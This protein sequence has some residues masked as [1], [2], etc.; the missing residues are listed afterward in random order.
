MYKLPSR[1][2]ATPFRALM[3]SATKIVCVAGVVCAAS[4]PA[5]QT[6]WTFHDLEVR[7]VAE[8]SQF[9]AGKFLPRPP[10]PGT[11]LLQVVGT[12][13]AGDGQAPFGPTAIT[14]IQLAAKD[15]AGQAWQASAVAAG[16]YASGGCQYFPAKLAPAR[17]AT[18]VL[19]PAGEA[20]LRQASEADAVELSIRA[21]EVKV[22]FA[23]ETPHEVPV[24]GILSA[25]GQTIRFGDEPREALNSVSLDTLAL[26]LIGAAAIAGIAVGLIL[27][28]RRRAKRS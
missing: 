17:S 3:A 18:V 19:R 10:A 26:W 23:F 25:A 20:N 7:R 21:A 28:R 16:T 9:N 12:L 5:A 14:G 27:L 4:A 8:I 1:V 22:C 24:S 6:S 11:S 2:A 15:P 13:R